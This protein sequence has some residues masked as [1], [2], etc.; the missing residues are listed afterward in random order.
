MLNE[1]VLD[2]WVDCDCFHGYSPISHIDFPAVSTVT[3]LFIQLSLCPHCMWPPLLWPP[4]PGGHNNVVNLA[5]NTHR[6]EF[7]V[8][9]LWSLVDGGL[10]VP[11]LQSVL[12]A[13]GRWEH[14]GVWRQRSR[15]T[16][17]HGGQSLQVTRHVYS[18]LMTVS[19]TATGTLFLWMNDRPAELRKLVTPD[20][21]FFFLQLYWNHYTTGLQ[22]LM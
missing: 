9:L 14:C 17:R 8:M 1:S 15:C 22:R 19:D 7:G 3:C 11:L 16:P 12:A 4:H 2:E 10:T 13:G 21:F 18:G 6:S 5:G 20:V